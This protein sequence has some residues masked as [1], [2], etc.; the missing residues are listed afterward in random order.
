MRTTNPSLLWSSMA[1]AMIRH[2]ITRR[3]RSADSSSFRCCG[4]KISW[5]PKCYNN[6][7]V[8][9]WVIAVYQL[10]GWDEAQAKGEVPFDEDFDPFSVVAGGRNGKM[11]PYWI[12]AAA[13]VGIQK[14]YKKGKL[15]SPITSGLIGE[16]E[17]G[18]LK[19]IEFLRI[20]ETHGI[21]QLN[22]MRAQ[23]FL[24]TSPSCCSS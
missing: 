19:G 14:V 18:N 7:S 8:L 13:Q 4:S 16:D 15:A 1:P 23:S 2:A 5:L 22:G 24:V 11:F 20:N 6:V 9:A 12:S 3:M 21:V 17:R 10:Q